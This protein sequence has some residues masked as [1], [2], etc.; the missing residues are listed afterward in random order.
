VSQRDF[1]RLVEK[2]IEA[3]H[4]RFDI[5]NLPCHF[6]DLDHAWRVLT[7]LPEDSSA[8]YFQQDKKVSADVRKL[9][10]DFAR[11]RGQRFKLRTFAPFFFDSS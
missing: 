10:S 1:A 6:F 2:C 5:S 7:Y 9:S 11:Q 8:A 4:V 3:T